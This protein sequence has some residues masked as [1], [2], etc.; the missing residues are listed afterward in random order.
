MN[1]SQINAYKHA[2]DR[3]G[4]DADLNAR[5]L[6]A[7]RLKALRVKDIQQAAPQAHDLQ[8]RGLQSRDLRIQ[9]SDRTLSGTRWYTRI[10][11][12]GTSTFILRKLSVVAA[13]LFVAVGLLIGGGVLYSLPMSWINLDINPSV[14]LGVN[15]MQRV[16]SV[17]GLNADGDVLVSGLAIKG[18]HARDAM[19]SLVRQAA[20]QGYLADG[21]D[22]V[23]SVTVI[24]KQVVRSEKLLSSVTMGTESALADSGSTATVIRQVASEEQIHQAEALKEKGHE[25]SPGKLLLIDKMAALAT[26]LQESNRNVNAAPFDVSAW[27][28]APVREIQQQIDEYRMQLKAK[29]NKD[30]FEKAE[31]ETAKVEEKTDAEKASSEAERAA[32]KA[33]AEAEKAVEKTEKTENKTKTEAEKAAEKAAAEAEK[34]AEKAEKSEDKTKT[35]AEKAAEKAAAEAEKAVEQPDKADDKAKTEAEKAAE[36][37]AAE[38]EKSDDKAKTE[39]EKAAEKAAAEAEKAEDKAKT[40]ADKAADKA[41]AEADKAAAEAEKTEDKAKTEADKAADKAA[42]EADKAAAEAEKADKHSEKATD[43]PDKKD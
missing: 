19:S 8:T 1:Q 10:A 26:Q 17:D 29:D 7:M 31:A 24:S 42:A 22:A 32:E 41:A 43:K 35:E 28:D 23:I 6:E 11:R 30:G 18:E 16:V 34:A 40:E 13:V 14:S 2:M 20:V 5:V 39:A 12:F 27:Y 36:K 25:I 33:A 4:P 38:A 37:A 3:I 9:Y 15:F 21:E